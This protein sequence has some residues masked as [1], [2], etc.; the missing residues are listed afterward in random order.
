METEKTWAILSTNSK[1][2]KWEHHSDYSILDIKLPKLIKIKEKDVF[3]NIHVITAKAYLKYNSSRI[4][5]IAE[6]IY[7]AARQMK[8]SDS[9]ITYNTEGSLKKIG[10]IKKS[11]KTGIN[12][13][14]IK[15][16]ITWVT[17]VPD[18]REIAVM[19]SEDSDILD[20]TA[21]KI[22]SPEIGMLGQK[23][24]RKKYRHVRRMPRRRGFG[25]RYGRVS[26]RGG[27][28]GRIKLGIPQSRQSLKGTVD[29]AEE[30]NIIEKETDKIDQGGIVSLF[31]GTN[32][33]ALRVN[34]NNYYGIKTDKLQYG[35]CK[36]SIPPGHIKGKLERP[37]KFLWLVELPEKK[38]KHVVLDGIKE[39]SEKEFKNRFVKV[40]SSSKDKEAMIFI[41]GYN[42]TFADAARRAAQL[43][44]DIPFR[45]IPAFFSW[46]SAG[47][48]IPYP[49]DVDKA[50]PS[51]KELGEF[52]EV[53]LSFEKLEKLHVIAH[54]MG[55][56]VLGLTIFN[57]SNKQSVKNKIKKIHQIILGAPDINQEEFKN[58]I[59][60][61]FGKVGRRRTLYV[62]DKDSPLKWS[63]KF[64][65]GIPRLGEAGIELFLDKQ[66]DT[67]DAS[68]VPASGGGH[69]YLFETNDVLV[70]LL[71][72]VVNGLSPEKRGLRERKRKQKKYWLFPITNKI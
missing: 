68:N 2:R 50:R 1:F 25:G 8:S 55:G 31:Y 44:Y 28:S 57:L 3:E 41:H 70:D 54:S 22:L 42:N 63:E 33:N 16:I 4:K 48:K 61:Q 29:S 11:D 19:L 40:L 34:L 43:A 6:R 65:G 38:N 12:N 7:N 13:N 20:I 37:S 51:S 47:R 64:R 21:L 60:P 9:V 62:S 45:G 15:I 56:L 58:N 26:Y 71:N 72:L 27:G 35:I 14:S 66:I 24:S 17:P 67:I 18:H 5:K 23:K 69:G 49:R 36:V 53:I 59:L 52:I 46:P 32:R 30:Y 10:I 39:L